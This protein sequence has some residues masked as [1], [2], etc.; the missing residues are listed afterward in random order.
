MIIVNFGVF[1]LFLLFVWVCVCVRVYK[2]DKGKAEKR[3]CMGGEKGEKGGWVGEGGW[4]LVLTN[5]NI[6]N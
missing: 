5:G 2:R 4:V 3:D 1:F 6:K